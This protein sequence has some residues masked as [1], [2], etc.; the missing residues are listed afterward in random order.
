MD[1]CERDDLFNSQASNFINSIK[2]KDTLPVSG[3]SGMRT[4]KVVLSAYESAKKK[5][6]VKAS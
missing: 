4:F 1:K 2:G 3:E 6:V 5:K